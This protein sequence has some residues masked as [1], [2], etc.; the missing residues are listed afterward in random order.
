MWQAVAE[1][2]ITAADRVYD[3]I[4]ARLEILQTFPEAGVV[5]PNIAPD[6]RLLIEPP[7]LIFYRI[8]PDA[9]Q[10]VRVLHGA[11]NIDAKLFGQGVE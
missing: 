9:I 6:A 10:I 11:R 7:Y 2:N 8:A 5:R 3:R 1:H 4:E